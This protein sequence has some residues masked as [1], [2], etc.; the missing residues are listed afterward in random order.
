MKRKT[1]R[2]K[3]TALECQ[4][5]TATGLKEE[6]CFNPPEVSIEF[7]C[8]K[9]FAFCLAHEDALDELHLLYKAP[10]SRVKKYTQLALPEVRHDGSG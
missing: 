7:K 10:K 3:K 1:S 6:Q 9:T 2:T 8:G 4:W 5:A